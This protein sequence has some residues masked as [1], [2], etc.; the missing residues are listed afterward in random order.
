MKMSLEKQLLEDMKVAMKAGDKV[1]LDTIRNLRSALKNEQ[2]SK[3][4]ELTDDEAQKVLRTAKKRAK[5]AIEQFKVGGRDD[6]VQEES[7]QLAV[8]E[9]YLPQQLSQEEIE[10]IVQQTIADVGAASMSDM[11]KVMGAVMAKVSGQADGKL[12]QQV[13]REKLMASS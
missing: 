8:I 2:I 1:R 4:D 7:A 9:S 3:G 11:G 6:R 10:Q 5:D 13:V 12:V